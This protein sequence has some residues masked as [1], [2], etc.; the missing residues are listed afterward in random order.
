MP[1]HRCNLLHVCGLAWLT[2]ILAS[3]SLAAATLVWDHDVKYNDDFGPGSITPKW[4]GGALIG[5]EHFV[6]DAPV[7]RTFDRHGAELTP[8]TFQIPGATVIGAVGFARGPD[9]TVALCGSADD[10][11]GRRVPYIALVAPSGQSVQVV[12]PIPLRPSW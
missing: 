4:N 7:V 12:R 8:L 11:A 10:A 9:G 5:V 1:E 6:S 2:V 3:H